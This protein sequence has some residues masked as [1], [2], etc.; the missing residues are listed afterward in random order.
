MN[1]YISVMP[2]VARIGER[3]TFVL[4]A[5]GDM[6]KPPAGASIW[7]SVNSVRDFRV[8]EDFVLTVDEEGKADFEFAPSLPGEYLVSVYREPKHW[9]QGASHRISF[10]AVGNELAEML[11]FK[12]DLH[13]HTTHSDGT[14]SA[15]YMVAKSREKGMDFIAM[16]DHRVYEASLEARHFAAENG[17]PTIVFRGEEVNYPLGIG[18]IV[19]L[20]A[21]RSVSEQFTLHETDSPKDTADAI[22]QATFMID[23]M[24]PLYG[25]EVASMDLPESVDRDLFLWSYGVAREIQKAGGLAIIAHPYWRQRDVIDLVSST[26]DAILEQ[27]VFDAVEVINGNGLEG[28]M[29]GIAKA[30]EHGWLDGSM[31]PFVGSSDAHSSGSL[32]S[33]Y[34][35]A[36]APELSEGA[37]LD[38]IRAART[39]ACIDHRLPEAMVVG[40]YE[41]VEYAYF[42]IREFFPLHDDLCVAQGGLY[43]ALERREV[44]H[45][46]RVAESLQERIDALYDAAFAFSSAHVTVG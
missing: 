21:D 10:F 29:L 14:R 16:T 33:R 45:A 1:P 22:R 35:I 17:L 13:M 32:G 26:Y 6:R 23:Q 12:G 8:N 44:D 4:H 39:V 43:K 9:S 40:R 20:N 2:L 41:L 37:I 5:V 18:H 46:A 25:E 36:F 24:R 7:V 3:T 42:L 28:V 27:Q 31:P 15:A 11:P 34:T 19:S 38:S 30:A